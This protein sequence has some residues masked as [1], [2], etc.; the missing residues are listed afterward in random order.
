MAFSIR[1]R[2]HDA[3]VHMLNLHTGRMGASALDDLEWP[4]VAKRLVMLR[5]RRGGVLTKS[6]VGL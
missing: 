6:R 3:V 5:T 2:Q 1:Q 4:A